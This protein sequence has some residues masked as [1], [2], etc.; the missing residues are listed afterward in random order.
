M[1]GKKGKRQATTRLML[2]IRI[3]AIRISA[4]KR[5]RRM[6][7]SWSVTKIRR[8]WRLREKVKSKGTREKRRDPRNS[9]KST[10]R[11]RKWMYNGVKT[12]NLTL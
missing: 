10:S 9:K 12:T 7:V 6:T 8:I 4:L 1:T 3:S 2:R 11:N 5:I